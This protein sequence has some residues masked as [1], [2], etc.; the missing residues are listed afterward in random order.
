MSIK[1]FCDWCGDDL[2]GEDAWLSVAHTVNGHRQARF[3][4]C[5]V[6]I[7]PWPSQPVHLCNLKCL[8]A[9]VDGEAAKYGHK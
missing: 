6:Y 2:T 3:S 4:T 1:T 9:W 5:D 7:Q 8:R